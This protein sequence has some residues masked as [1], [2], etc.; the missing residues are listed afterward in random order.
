MADG[1]FSKHITPFNDNVHLPPYY[2][3][4]IRTCNLVYYWQSHNF[5]FTQ[6][7]IRQML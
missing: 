2:C 6:E 1:V 5:I 3:S 7:I 4:L